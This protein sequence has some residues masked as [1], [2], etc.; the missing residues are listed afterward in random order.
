[1]IFG[2]SFCLNFKTPSKS[3]DNFFYSPRFNVFQNPYNLLGESFY[4]LIGH[5]CSLILTKCISE[6]HNPIIIWLITKPPWS[7]YVC[8]GHYVGMDCAGNFKSRRSRLAEGILPYR[9]SQM[10]TEEER[11]GNDETQDHPQNQKEGKSENQMDGSNTKF[12]AFPYK[13]YSIQVDFMNA[14]H[15]SLEKGGVSMLES[16]TGI[17][18]F[19]KFLTLHFTIHYPLNPSLSSLCLSSLSS[20]S[21]CVSCVGIPVCALRILNL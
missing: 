6:S 18:S 1:M 14:L 15:H 5:I 21:L 12:P 11:R 17:H 20:K 8:V 10:T 7:V 19:S 2:A 13:P 3:F 4:D 16:P 9:F